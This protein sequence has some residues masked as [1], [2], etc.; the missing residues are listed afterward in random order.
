MR[1]AL[2]AVG[3]LLAA[4]AE[5]QVPGDPRIQS[6]EYRPG[7]IFPLRAAPGFQVTVELAPD[8]HVTSVALGDSAAWQVTANKAGNLLFVRPT[9]ASVTTNMTV[10]TDVRTYHFDLIGADAGSGDQPYALRFNYPTQDASATLGQMTGTYRLRGDKSLFPKAISDD[11]TRTF[12]DWP[13]S[14]PLPAIYAR[15]RDG[16]ETLLNGNMR[17]DLFVIDGVDGD[18]VFRVDKRR[19]RATRIE[20]R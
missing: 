8:E 18:L 9:D 2:L 13:A 10:V 15:D 4:P 1:S 7:Q 3:I 14:G 12:I 19:A 16:R 11:G 6:V 17:G 5:A 20:G